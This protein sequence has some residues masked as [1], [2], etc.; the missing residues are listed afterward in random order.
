[1]SKK[2]TY[3]YCNKLVKEFE[4]V[5]KNPIKEKTS[6]YYTG[7]DLGTSCIVLAVLDEISSSTARTIHDVPKSTPV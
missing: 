7:V 1:M 5:I 4:K 6:T 2:I 3:D